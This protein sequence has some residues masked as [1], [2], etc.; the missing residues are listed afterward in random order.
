MRCNEQC[1]RC[2]RMRHD[3][4]IGVWGGRRLQCRSRLVALH[5][6][7]PVRPGRRALLHY[8]GATQLRCGPSSPSSRP[9]PRPPWAGLAARGAVGEA[10]VEV[11][12]AG[13]KEVGG[14]P[15]HEVAA[16]RA[17]QT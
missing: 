11:A 3:I 7:H 8:G 16:R 13:A 14:E 2:N 12:L 10:G 15:C 17:V 4:M 9:G 5:R 1:N 6:H